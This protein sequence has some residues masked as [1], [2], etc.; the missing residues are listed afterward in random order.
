M[1]TK[2]D[3]SIV[4]SSGWYVCMAQQIY[5]RRQIHDVAML[6]GM[7]VCAAAAKVLKTLLRHSRSVHPKPANVHHANNAAHGC[8]SGKLSTCREQSC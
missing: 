7:L 3:L 2:D 1:K 8:L 5:S 4:T 6:G